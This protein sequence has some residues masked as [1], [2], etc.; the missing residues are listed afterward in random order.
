[1]HPGILARIVFSA[2]LATLWLTTARAA[3]TQDDDLAS[4]FATA[5]DTAPDQQQ[6]VQIEI[7]G[8]DLGN[9]LIKVF[10]GRVTLPFATL[11]ALGIA[12]RPRTSLDL[13]SETRIATRFD[14]AKSTLA[15][16]VPV[17][18]LSAQRFAPEVDDVQVRLSPET[19]GAYVNYD[20]NLRYDFGQ[21][22]TGTSAGREGSVSR[23][24]SSFGAVG[25]LAELRVL[26]PDVVGSGGWAYDSTRLGP[27]ALVRLDT[28]LTWR[29]TWLN[30]A[31]SAGDLVSS[32]TVSLAATRPY[33]FAGL[34]VCRS[35]PI[36]AARRPG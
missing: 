29:P 17:S 13:S 15:L 19:W 30:M 21:S 14:E 32:T 1:M 25:G 12:G 23:G 16:T 18:M 33:R 34:P 6:L 7:N 4:R 9:Q 31:V 11:A 27:D 2:V 10:K 22:M 20:F 8:V 28:T 3:A 26:A 24:R 5:P 36:T 35:A